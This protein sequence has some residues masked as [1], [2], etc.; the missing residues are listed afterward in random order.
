MTRVKTRSIENIEQKMEGVAPDSLRYK[1]LDNAKMFK[2]SWV[3]LG[4][5][6]Y[7]VWK[8]KSYREWGYIKFDTYTAKEIGIRK[9]TALKLLRSY[10]FLEK[11]EPQYLTKEY[12][13][14]TSCATV[15]TYESVDVLRLAKKRKN[16]DTSDYASIRRGVLEKGKDVR[17]VKKDLTALIKQ[18]EE[19]EP[20]EAR[21]KRKDA[22]VK[23]LLSVLKSVKKEIKISHTL[24]AQLIKDTEKLIDSLEAEVSQ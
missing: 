22:L 4:Q 19:L 23:R 10:F 14:A 17:E 7:A 16:I 9:Q 3:G 2:T 5:A 21:Q 8:D 6:L 11:E 15:P 24:P 12:S 1:V 18:R 13:E 20:E